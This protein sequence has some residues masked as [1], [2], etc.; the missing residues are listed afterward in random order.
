MEYKLPKTESS[1]EA[2]A[3]RADTRKASN[4]VGVISRAR[5]GWYKH[6]CLIRHRQKSTVSLPK[7]RCCSLS[8]DRLPSDRGEWER[9]TDFFRKTQLVS[10][11]VESRKGA[12]A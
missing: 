3:I 1:K 4:C 7:P 6:V 12:V 10:S 11:Y 5:P 9:G 2:L 8:W